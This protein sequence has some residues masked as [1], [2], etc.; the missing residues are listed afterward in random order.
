VLPGLAKIPEASISVSI[1]EVLVRYRKEL[2]VL[3]PELILTPRINS[4][5]YY[6]NYIIIYNY[7]I[8]LIF[9]LSNKS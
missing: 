7:I 4:F 9:S 5:F 3:I 6:L 8:L 1:V 2:I